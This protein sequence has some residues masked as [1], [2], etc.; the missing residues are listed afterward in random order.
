MTPVSPV[1]A[2]LEQFEVVFGKNQP[3]FM[4]LPALVGRLPEVHVV[5]RWELSADERKAIAEGADVYTIQTTYNDAFQPLSVQ[6]G[7]VDQDSRAFMDAF[8]I[9]QML[10]EEKLQQ[11]LDG[12]LE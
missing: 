5:S 7:G 12:L 6:I 3:Q 8:N 2:G 11:V 10:D 9:G 4:P 1:V